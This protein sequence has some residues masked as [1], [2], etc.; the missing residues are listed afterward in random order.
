MR[1]VIVSYSVQVTFDSADPAELAKFWAA[2]LG[3]V[4]QRPPAG[5]ESW[6]AFLETIG[7]DDDGSASAVVDPEGKGPRLFF[8]LVPEGRK[9]K[10]RVHLD[11]NAGGEHGTPPGV[12]RQRVEAE[13]ERLT[14]IGATF[15][16]RFDRDGEYWVVLDDPEGNVFCLQ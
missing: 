2:A 13:A 7:R 11:V 6:Q 10:N 1:E 12:R 8:Q 9:A 15:R 14:G 16:E 5:F 4:E 3:Y